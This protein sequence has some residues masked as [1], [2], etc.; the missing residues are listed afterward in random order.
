MRSA[1]GQSGFENDSR[2]PV[3]RAESGVDRDAM[4]DAWFDR[5]ASPAEAA[6]IRELMRQDPKLSETFVRTQR[7]VA[8]LRRPIPT[9]D[10]SSSV[11]RRVHGRRRFLPE[12]VRRVVMSGRA[13]VAAAVLAGLLT[14]AVIERTSPD[15]VSLTGRST[16]VSAVMDVSQA[17][18]SQGARQLT[19][20]ICSLPLDFVQPAV[21]VAVV[22]R[23]RESP[24]YRLEVGNLRTVMLLGD[25]ESASG[26]AS[27]LV[28]AGAGEPAM[29]MSA[30][31]RRADLAPA[32]A[33]AP[34][35]AKVIPF[36]FASPAT[37]T[38][39]QWRESWALPQ[40]VDVG[41]VGESSLESLRLMHRV[42]GLD[43]V[44]PT[45]AEQ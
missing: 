45:Q 1:G 30:R 17:E 21:E 9:L 25:R 4:L 12:R 7:V 37:P 41:G 27:P 28:T 44:S 20:A 43:A 19:Q 36:V 11:L 32:F 42:L 34:T 5:E 13:A 18:L 10:V 15:A 2:P 26:P 33:H 16:P 3:D 23:Q 38:F 14:V 24:A 40:S 35:Q 39:I 29:V 8:M 31:V 6:R 22:V